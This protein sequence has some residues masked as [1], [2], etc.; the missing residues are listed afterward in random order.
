MPSCWIRL[1][2]Q[3]EASPGA[4]Q[5][6]SSSGN[7]PPFSLFISWECTLNPEVRYDIPVCNKNKIR[8]SRSI[9][10]A[11]MQCFIL[12]ALLSAL[13]LAGILLTL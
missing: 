4:E 7:K 2:W 3:M 8:I 13:F 9:I 12:E 1:V 10:D 11:D 5:Q 6:Q